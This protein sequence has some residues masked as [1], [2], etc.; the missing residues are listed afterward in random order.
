MEAALQ[1]E[2]ER[3]LCWELDLIARAL[4][5]RKTRRISP[6]WIDPDESGFLIIKIAQSDTNVWDRRRVGWPEFEAM[7]QAAERAGDA[8]VERRPV[9]SEGGAEAREERTA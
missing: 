3:R 9:A 4:V 1:T 7:I 2:E 6:V 5:L 8:R